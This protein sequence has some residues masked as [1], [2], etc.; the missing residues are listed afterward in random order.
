MAMKTR[1]GILGTGRISRTFAEALAVIPGAELVAVG[2]RSSAS[3]EEFGA[4]FKARRAH[5]TYEALA[6]DP[7]VEAIYIGTPHPLH[8]E[9]A[10]LCLEAGKAVLIEKPF[11]M[12]EREARRMVETARRTKRFLM[13]AMWTHFLPA[14]VRAFELVGKGAIGELRMIHADFGFKAPYD[15]KGRLFDPALGGGS[16]LDVGVYPVSFA[17]RLFGEPARIQSSAV[18][19]QSGVDEQAA[20]LL[21]YDGGRQAVLSSAVRTETSHTAVLSGSEGRIKIERPFWRGQRLIVS[22]GDREETIDLPYE[23][24]GYPHEAREVMRCLAEG[25]LESPRMTHEFSLGVM[26]TLDRIRA[27]WGMRYPADA[28]K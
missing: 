13:E 3:A 10:I 17:S 2:S 5:A 22:A 11:A 4:K 12:H 27:P 21:E 16:L 26:R 18:L 14:V 7:E 1:W 25:L 28:T 19:G 8:C 23:G 24:N 15:P 20:M 9:N 6:R